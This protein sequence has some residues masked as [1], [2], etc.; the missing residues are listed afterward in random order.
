MKPAKLTKI[1]PVFD[2]GG[3]GDTAMLN[4][5]VLNKT[6]PTQNP[7]LFN[8]HDCLLE[9]QPTDWFSGIN[10]SWKQSQ[11]VK[12]FPDNDVTR[13]IFSSV[14]R[15]LRIIN[16]HFQRSLFK[17]KYPRVTRSNVLLNSSCVRKSGT[18]FSVTLKA[19]RFQSAPRRELPCY[20]NLEL[21]FKIKQEPSSSQVFAAIG[22]SVK[23]ETDKVQ[24]I[25]VKV[26]SDLVKVERDKER[27]KERDRER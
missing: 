8:I 1:W 3:F 22:R 23:T 10:A 18:H 15:Q 16:T 9:P 21:P 17:Y 13:K 27:V 12:K 24:E 14:S 25:K 11:L 4:L 7:L 26:E 6:P 20:G 5:H 2:S 19:I